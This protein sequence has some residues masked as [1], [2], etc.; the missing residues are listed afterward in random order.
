MFMCGVHIIRNQLLRPASIRVAA[1][2][3]SASAACTAQVAARKADLKESNSAESKTLK[4]IAEN[5]KLAIAQRSGF[6]VQ[7][8]ADNTV[9]WLRISDVRFSDSAAGR[10]NLNALD[11]GRTGKNN[12]VSVSAARGLSSKDLT[13]ATPDF[14][15]VQSLASLNRDVELLKRFRDEGGLREYS[16]APLA[17]PARPAAAAPARSGPSGVKINAPSSNPK[18]K[19]EDW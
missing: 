10:T 6:W 12:I 7:V 4:S 5:S 3:L 8:K 2:L 13:D 19:N 1:V 16:I 14:S 11:S 18:D 15:A 17:P 9:G